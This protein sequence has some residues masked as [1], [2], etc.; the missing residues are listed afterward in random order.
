[1]MTSSFLLTRIKQEKREKAILSPVAV[2]SGASAGRQYPENEHDYRTCFQRDRDRIIHCEAFRR[3]KYKTQVFLT[4]SGDHY[5]T[6]LTHTIEV[7][8]IARTIARVLSVNED[9]TEALALAHDLG[10]PPFGHTGERILNTRMEARGG[11]EHNAQALRIVDCL[12]NRYP[13]FPGLNLTAETRRGILKH[14]KPYPG[15]GEGL[16][17]RL[18]LEAQIVDIADEI[19]YTSHDLDDGIT[20]GILH[21]LDLLGVTLWREA[22]D[23]VK[24]HHP[25]LDEKRTWYQIV[26]GVINSQVTDVLQ[27][28]SRRLEEVN[29]AISNTLVNYSPAMQIQ[30]DEA[31]NFLFQQLYRNEKVMLAGEHCETV[32][33]HLFDYYCRQPAQLPASF[34]ERIEAAGL[35]RTV[36]DYISGMTDRF[37]LESH[38]QLREPL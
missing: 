2:Q 37:A 20:Y 17:T 9:L 22:Y 18:S 12:E 14:K 26:L 3:L 6:R 25:Q 21:P 27:E 16:P 11:F 8:Q 23:S 29:G 34:Q 36:A 10:H 24:H 13:Q 7:S 32:L 4:G 35:E 33:N 5:R 1:M 38:K 31:K 15:M 19:S 30:V 28:T